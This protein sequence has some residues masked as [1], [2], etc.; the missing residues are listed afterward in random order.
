M[1]SFRL[2]IDLAAVKLY[3]SLFWLT[4]TMYLTTYY[5]RT[6][7][8]LSLAI[9]Q[10]NASRLFFHRSIILTP[11]HQC[12][13]KQI[14]TLQ[15]KHADGCLAVFSMARKLTQIRDSNWPVV[16][17]SILPT[18]RS[19]AKWHW[20]LRWCHCLYLHNSCC[21]SSVWIAWHRTVL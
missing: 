17:V 19:S 9:N 2:K 4:T 6:L 21:W 16:L 13:Q 14:E 12:C 10:W 20:I 11:L 15:Y 7:S 5:S 3:N 1:S 18:Q 8:P